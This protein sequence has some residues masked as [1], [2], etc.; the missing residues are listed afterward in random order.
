MIKILVPRRTIEG[1]DQENSETV[2]ISS[3]IGLI[4]GGKARLARLAINY[5]AAISENTICNPRAIIIIWL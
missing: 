4:V 1:F 5:Q 3:P 2:I